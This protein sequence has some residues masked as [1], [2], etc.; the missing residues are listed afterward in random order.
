VGK[1]PVEERR[2]DGATRRRSDGRR[3]AVFLD[4]DGVI[5]RP[6]VRDG[7][8]YP[9]QSRDEFELLP[10]VVTACSSLKQAG[11]LL[12]VA[13]N[14]PD[15]GRGT[16]TV[17]VV[18]S[19]HQRMQEE[20]PLDEVMVCLHAGESFGQSCSCRKPQPGMLFQAAKKWDIDLAHSFMV[21]DRWRDVDC[22]VAAGC[23]TIFIDWGY[24]EALKQQPDFHAAD[25]AGAAQII[26][27]LS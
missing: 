16:L 7:L 26:L 20:L 23:R 14:Q 13:T 18:N 10:G 12:I 1:H 11:Y 19:I 4:R 27:S 21:G 17:E 24:A 22:G 6:L 3:R 15:V 2:G 8:P 5:N 25:L 9:P